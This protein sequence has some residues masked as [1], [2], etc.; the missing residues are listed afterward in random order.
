M[1]EASMPNPIPS[2]VAL[3]LALGCSNA[4]PAPEAPLEATPTPVAEPAPEAPL[5]A[6]P[7]PVAEAPPEATPTPVAE[8]EVLPETT[9]MGS[10]SG[11][12][13]GTPCSIRYSNGPRGGGTS[14][15]SCPD[16]QY[17]NCNRMAGYS[18][19]GE[20]YTKE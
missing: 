10:G 15:D 16:G 19:G 7:T 14:T 13:T 5:E 6:T 17:C 11:Q 1:N 4:T 18:C 20:C 2:I 8:P 3:A 9:L 12:P